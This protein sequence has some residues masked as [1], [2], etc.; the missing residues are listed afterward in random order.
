MTD[1]DSTLKVSPEAAA[2]TTADERDSDDEDDDKDERALELFKRGA[3]WIG[4]A[5][6]PFADAYQRDQEIKV[7]RLEQSDA[8]VEREV[9]LRLKLRELDSAER[10]ERMRLGAFLLTLLLLLAG[11]ALSLNKEAFAILVLTN[12]VALMGGFFLG[13]ATKA[14]KR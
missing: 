7:K 8:D 13:R 11:Y 2:T 5:V 12:S 9:A 14:T 1:D 3:A 10:R 6:K 4:K